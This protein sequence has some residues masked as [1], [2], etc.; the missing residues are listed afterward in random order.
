M[1][2]RRR[3]KMLRYNLYIKYG[4]IPFLIR[5]KPQLCDNSIV[6]LSRKN[7][8]QWSKS[9]Y[10]CFQLNRAQIRYR[11]CS[12]IILFNISFKPVKD[13]IV[14]FDLPIITHLPC[15]ETHSRMAQSSHSAIFF[16]LK[17]LKWD[18]C[19]FFLVYL[20]FNL[21]GTFSISKDGLRCRSRF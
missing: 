1:W 2:M 19:V 3:S 20:I 7:D 14:T 4:L 8:K 11:W 17:L 5:S 6:Q 13:H 21:I 9:N 12:E 18:G 16:Y 15:N 10:S